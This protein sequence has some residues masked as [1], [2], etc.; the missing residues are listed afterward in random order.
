MSRAFAKLY[1]CYLLAGLITSVYTGD[2]WHL[3]IAVVAVGI[4]F[5][6]FNGISGGGPG[7]SASP[8]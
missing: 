2:P 1:L 3:L 4:L 8:R 5:A 7:G 6:V